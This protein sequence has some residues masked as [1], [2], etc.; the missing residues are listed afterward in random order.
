MTYFPS[1]EGAP[2]NYRR[3]LKEDHVDANILC[4][5]AMGEL[6]WDGRPQQIEFSGTVN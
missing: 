3:N 4:F 6:D 2:E 5:N 1:N